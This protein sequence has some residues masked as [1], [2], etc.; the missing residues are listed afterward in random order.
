MAF[1]VVLDDQL[2][3]GHRPLDT[4]RAI[5]T[6]HLAIRQAAACINSNSVSDNASVVD[7]QGDDPTAAIPGDDCFRW[8]SN[9][10]PVLQPCPNQ[11]AT[12]MSGKAETAE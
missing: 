1:V 9:D 11:V 10:A 4:N 12:Y 6:N 2:G 5:A 8:L 3:A 7:R